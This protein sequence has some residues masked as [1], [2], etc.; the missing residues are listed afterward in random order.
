MIAIRYASHH[1]QN[2][3]VPTPF[4][5]E[6]YAEKNLFQW[7]QKTYPIW[8]LERSDSDAVW[9]KHST[10]MHSMISKL[11]PNTKKYSF[12]LFLIFNLLTLKKAVL[13]NSSK[14]HYYGSTFRQFRI[15]CLIFALKTCSF[16]ANIYLFKVNN[17]N[18]RKMCVMYSKFTIRHWRHWRRSGVY[19]VNFKYISLLFR[20]FE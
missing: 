13:C 5:Y 16:P 17:R 1:C 3:S 14:V 20:V 18:T 19:I 9:W 12:W 10:S 11:F 6:N 7:K 8:K 4:H 2:R 15:I